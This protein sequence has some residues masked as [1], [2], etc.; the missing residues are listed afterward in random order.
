MIRFLVHARMRA[1]IYNMVEKQTGRD[2]GDL[3]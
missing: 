3:S 2:I 1:S